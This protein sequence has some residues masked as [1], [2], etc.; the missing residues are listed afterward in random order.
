MPTVFDNIDTP[1]LENDA[2]NGLKD[3]LEVA[4]RGDFCV[5]Y[6]NLRGWRCIDAVVNSWPLPIAGESPHEPTRRPT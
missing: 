3:A 1:F 4:R 5:G 2:R 6:F